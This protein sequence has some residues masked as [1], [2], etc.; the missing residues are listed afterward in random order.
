MQKPVRRVKKVLRSALSVASL[1]CVSAGISGALAQRA[2]SVPQP[3]QSG[4][5]MAPPAQSTPPP[6]SVQQQQP[7]P[8][9]SAPGLLDKLG[10]IIKETV[11]DMSA[12]LKGTRSTIDNLNKGAA[13]TLTRL[14]A[15]GIALGRA[16]CP[17]AA[18]GAPDCQVATDTL[19]KSKGYATG[20]SLGTETAETCAPRV[21]VPGYQRKDG[22]CTID[23]YVTRAACN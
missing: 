13:D 9:A 14:P 3:S 22:D 18:N 15:G 10:D 7:M 4:L 1:A 16:I 21:Y 2:P 11:D 5:Q 23:T 17:R 19:C 6:A 8:P 12:N 20:T